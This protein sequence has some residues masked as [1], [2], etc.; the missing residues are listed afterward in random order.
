VG[1][2]VVQLEEVMLKVVREGLLA[3]VADAPE[4]D[5]LSE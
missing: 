2:E 5:P 1:A 3:E 4:E